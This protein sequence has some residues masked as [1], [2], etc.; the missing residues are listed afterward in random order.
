V[1]DY[2]D[3]SSLVA[4]VHEFS[5]FSFTQALNEPGEGSITLDEDSPFWTAILNNGNSNRMLLNNEYVFEAIDNGVPRFAWLATSVTNT[6]IGEDEARGVTI[7]GPG[8]AAVLKWAK[9][10]RPGWPTKVPITGYKDVEVG[11]PPKI[12]KI[13]IYR[14]VANTDKLS[15]YNWQFP[16]KWPTMRMWYTVFQ[17]AQRRGLLKWVKP[18]FTAT[19]DSEK[20]DW[21]WIKTIEA[22]ATKE[23]YQPTE[24][25]QNLLDFLDDCTGQDYS[26]WFGQRL[27]WIMYPG[28]K[29]DVRQR[30]GT[31][32]SGIERTGHSNFHAVRFFSGNILGEERTRD[33]EEIHNRVIAMDVIGNESN[34]TD[35]ASI[36]KWNL[37]E[38]WN[39]TNKNVTVDTL[40]NQVADRYIQQSKD[41]KDQW[42]IKIP[43][44]DPGRVPYR[45]FYVGDWIGVNAQ[46]LGSTPTAAGTPEKF[47]VMAITVRVSTDSTVPECELTLNSLIDTKMAELEKQITQLLNNPKNVDFDQIKQIDI[48]E[49]PDTKKVLVYNPKTKKWEPGP[50]GSGGTGTGG[51]VYIGPIAPPAAE[52][53]DLW[54]ETYD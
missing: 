19:K 1:L 15:A 14:D 17:A 31:D 34:R 33:R 38:Q 44:D 36:A 24:R 32:R 54:M 16:M 39:E 23:G 35:A 29:L 40:R 5:E 28:F 13:A 27:E 46:Y 6:L 18:M 20:K 47:R 2:K 48:P 21:V 51:A 11:D 53:G 45:N 7:S 49:A 26:K 9:V 42:T 12:E 50:A 41:E 10:G 25:N 8:I 3:M 52:P 37:R 43:Y 22:L 4:V 30:I